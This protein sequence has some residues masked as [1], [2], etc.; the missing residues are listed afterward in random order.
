MEMDAESG[1]YAGFESLFMGGNVP[2]NYALGVL[3]GAP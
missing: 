3:R 2:S 1:K